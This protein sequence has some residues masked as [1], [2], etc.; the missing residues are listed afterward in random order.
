M[1]RTVLTLGTFDLFHAGHVALLRRCAWMAGD[2]HVVVGL[3]TDAFVE[4][5]KGRP[6]VIGYLDR[7]EVLKACRYVTRV[8]P[9]DQADGSI[10][11][12]LDAVR[13]DLIVVGDDWADRDYLA[14][15]GLT[16]DDLMAYGTRIEYLS[17]TQGI[18][19]T[20]IKERMA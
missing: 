4:R 18:S 6:P 13:P 9:N 2:P 7:A 5:Y 14:Q 15:L 19:S 17:Y 20:A 10:R 3:N 11:D 16:R 8:V 1:P 12:V